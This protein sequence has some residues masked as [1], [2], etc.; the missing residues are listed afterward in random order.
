MY[1]HFFFAPIAQFYYLL[2]LLLIGFLA[3]PNGS[4]PPSAFIENW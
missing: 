2:S 3:N 4:T 1:I